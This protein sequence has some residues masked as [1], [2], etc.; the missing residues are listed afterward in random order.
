MGPGTPDTVPGMPLSAEQLEA[1]R[2]WALGNLVENRNR[3]LFAEWLVGTALG[4]TDKERLEWDE[5][6]HAEP[7]ASAGC[8][9]AHSPHVYTHRSGR[10]VRHQVA[11]L[12]RW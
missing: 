2:R 4:I 8:A 6:D 3:G 11:P 1:F 5:A 9:G 10:R 7:Q 12:R